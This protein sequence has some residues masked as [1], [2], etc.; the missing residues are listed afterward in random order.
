[1]KIIEGGVPVRLRMD[2][3]RSCV[4]C[5]LV[6]HCPL[7]QKEITAHFILLSIHIKSKKERPFRQN[8]RKSRCKN[9]LSYHAKP[10]L[11]K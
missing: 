4:R 2:S 8:F 10:H 3:K 9:F 6:Q 1:M 5:Q 11:E 7:L